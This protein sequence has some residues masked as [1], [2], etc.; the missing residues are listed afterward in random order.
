MLKRFEEKLAFCV[1]LH[2]AN[3]YIEQIHLIKL[4]VIKKFDLMELT[5]N[6]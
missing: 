3:I 4:I 6:Q 1:G 5:G 2:R